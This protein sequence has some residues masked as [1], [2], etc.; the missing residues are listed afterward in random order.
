[1]DQSPTP[2]LGLMHAPS[3][4]ARESAVSAGDI[5]ALETGDLDNS[6]NPF[7]QLI[8]DRYVD[9]KAP[10]GDQSP[11]DFYASKSVPEILAYNFKQFGGL[12]KVV[13][14]I[15]SKDNCR[16]RD[17]GQLV[18]RAHFWLNGFRGSQRVRK[19]TFHNRFVEVFFRCWHSNSRGVEIVA[20]EKERAD[21]QADLQF[22]VSQVQEF[23]Q[24]A[25]VENEVGTG[26]K[27]LHL[28]LAGVLDDAGAGECPAGSPAPAPAAVTGG[29]LPEKAAVTAEDAGREEN[30]IPQVHA[31][32]QNK[33]A[34][35]YTVRTNS[36]AANRAI[37]K[38]L[39]KF[40]KLVMQ[41]NTQRAGG[42]GGEAAAKGGPAAAEQSG[43]VPEES[44][45]EDAN[46]FFDQLD[47][48]Y[49]VHLTEGLSCPSNSERSTSKSS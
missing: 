13:P 6:R 24:W 11:A 17:L 36:P 12:V 15:L 47:A 35:A 34:R 40:A 21:G 8:G 18:A 27:Q 19:V 30:R 31:V 5:E 1:M 32:K 45:Q 48:M 42:H 23:L 3:S 38:M 4:P 7:G 10:L 16:I 28:I 33:G 41:E 46:T 20:S 43:V 39:W 37:E 29:G 22:F 14:I 25:K 9:G 26:P 49:D 2:N 44:R